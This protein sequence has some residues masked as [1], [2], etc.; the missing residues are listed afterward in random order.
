MHDLVLKSLI[1]RAVNAMALPEGGQ[2]E[3]HL[4]PEHSGHYLNA[5]QIPRVAQRFGVEAKT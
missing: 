3:I 5:E 2:I 1:Q 4:P